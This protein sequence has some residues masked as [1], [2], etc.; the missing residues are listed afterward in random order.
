MCEREHRDEPVGFHVTLAPDVNEA[1]TTYSHCQRMSCP[2]QPAVDMMV[3][4]VYLTQTAVMNLTCEMFSRKRKQ[5]PQMF[6]Q[7]K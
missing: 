7:Q 4:E 3:L 5:I 6:L 2:L 1:Q